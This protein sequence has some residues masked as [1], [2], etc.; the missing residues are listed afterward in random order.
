MPHP[1]WL[2]RDKLHFHSPATTPPLPLI[3]EGPITFLLLL[4]PPPDYRRTNYNSLPAT[5]TP[6][7]I[8]EGKDKFLLLLPYPLVRKDKLNFH[9]AN[10]PPLSLDYG[11]I[12]YS[13]AKWLLFG[14]NLAPYPSI[15]K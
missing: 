12:R 3:T 13:K 15:F 10:T 5:T 2:R 9:P 6:P 8:T 4:I 11:R 1:H 14:P 7:L